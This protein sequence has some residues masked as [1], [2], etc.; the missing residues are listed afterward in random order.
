MCLDMYMYLY[1]DMYID[2]VLP[3]PVQLWQYYCKS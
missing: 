3:V 1:C 2:V